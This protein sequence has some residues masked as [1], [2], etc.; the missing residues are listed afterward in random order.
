MVI[1]YYNV[2]PLILVWANAHKVERHITGT[3]ATSS[4]MQVVSDHQ[5]LDQLL[6]YAMYMSREH[7]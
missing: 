7:A 2:Y 6:H 1:I 3:D 4:I 5:R